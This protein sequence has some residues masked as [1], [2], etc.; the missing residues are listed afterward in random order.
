MTAPSQ[1]ASPRAALRIGIKL[2]F[3]SVVWLSEGEKGGNS[4]G[5]KVNET[6]G[7]KLICFAA[8]SFAHISTHVTRT[9]HLRRRKARK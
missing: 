5:A 3:Q 1:R 6:E 9:A 2:S 7:E 8:P 4:A